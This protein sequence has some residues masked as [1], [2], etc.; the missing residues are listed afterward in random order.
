MDA[1]RSLIFHE[2]F[3]NWYTTITPI[4]HISK[5]PIASR[6]VSRGSESGV[7]FENLRAIPWGFA[8]TQTRYLVPGW[9]GTGKALYSMI[10]QDTEKLE[11]LRQFYKDW[12]F[13]QVILDNAQQEM[14]RTRLEI[15]KFY[16]AMNEQGFADRIEEEFEQAKTAI[17]KITG[18]SEILENRKAI[19]KTIQ[20]RNPYTD[21]LNL[22]QVELMKR[23]QQEK[24]ESRRDKLQY[25]LFLSI[26]AIA[27]AMQSTG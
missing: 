14:A 7:D 4:Q 2:K 25:A 24:D 17:L 1:Y 16:A 13:F 20:L 8:W 18:Q 11:L 27:A 12:P 22:V 26:N 23:W 15:S 6:P 5:L 10:E 19:K 3:W 21:V 9:F